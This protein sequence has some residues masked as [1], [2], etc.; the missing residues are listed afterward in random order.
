MFAGQHGAGWVLPRNE[1]VRGSIPPS[2]L[3]PADQANVLFTALTCGNAIRAVFSLFAMIVLLV[4]VLT[5]GLAT[6]LRRFRVWFIAVDGVER[7][8]DTADR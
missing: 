2:R 5:V 4:P 8:L 3:H 6:V 7:V 1:Q